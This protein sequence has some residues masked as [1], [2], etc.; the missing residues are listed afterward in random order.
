MT[1]RAL[2]T[3]GYPIDS[4]WQIGQIVEA[5]GTRYR[6]EPTGWRKVK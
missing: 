4:V 1:R 2:R 6:I 3:R 5:A